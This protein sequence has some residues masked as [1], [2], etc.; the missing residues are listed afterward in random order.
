MSEAVK[1]IVI[2]GGGTAGWITAALLGRRLDRSRYRLTLVE[3]PGVGTIGVGGAFSF[4]PTKNLGAFG[5]GGA[6]VTNDGSLAA[7]TPCWL[8]AKDDVSLCLTGTGPSDSPI[9]L[10]AGAQFVVNPVLRGG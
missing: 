6:V 3:S 8:F 9:P 5:D 2:V 7:H 10:T 4:Y 1:D